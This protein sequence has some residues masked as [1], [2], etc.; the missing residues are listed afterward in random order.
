[1]KLEVE[2]LIGPNGL[3]SQSGQLIYDNIHPEL[4]AGN[5]VELDFA[6]VRTF[7]T[8]FLNTAIGQ[9]YKDLKQEQIKQSWDLVKNDS[10]SLDTSVDDTATDAVLARLATQA[11][12]GYDLFMI[13]A[14]LKAGITQVITDDGDYVTVPGIQVFTANKN[15]VNLARVQGKLMTR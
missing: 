15:V 3:S 2:Q 14:M 10:Q 11:L 12:D 7:A 5:P 8:P 9:L 6:G 1:M 13:E 4:L